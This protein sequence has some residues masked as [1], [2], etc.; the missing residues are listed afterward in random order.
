MF[1]SERRNI[2]TNTILTAGFTASAGYFRALSGLAKN[3]EKQC[4]EFYRS[5][6]IQSR[7]CQNSYDNKADSHQQTSNLLLLWAAVLGPILTK[8]CLSRR[9][10]LRRSLLLGAGAVASDMVIDD[11]T[12]SASPIPD[13]RL[14]EPYTPPPTITPIPGPEISP[15]QVDFFPPSTATPRRLPNQGIV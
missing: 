7:N 5:G 12:F 9:D 8:G 4:R 2:I 15:P 3:Q 14:S 13:H 6:S 10:F 1:S 11:S